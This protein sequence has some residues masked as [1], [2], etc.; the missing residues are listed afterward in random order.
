MKMKISVFLWSGVKVQ[1][2]CITALV[3][4]GDLK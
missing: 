1:H 3:A 4:E 2:L